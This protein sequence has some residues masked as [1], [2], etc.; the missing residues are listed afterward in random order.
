MTDTSDAT[1]R[2]RHSVLCTN[3][4]HG[5]QL[6][7]D[8]SRTNCTKETKPCHLSIYCEQVSRN[9]MPKLITNISASLALNI[10]PFFS[11]SAVRA[12]FACFGRLAPRQEFRQRETSEHRETSKN[13]LHFKI[14]ARF[15][16]QS[17]YFFFATELQESSKR[18]EKANKD[19]VSRTKTP[20]EGSASLKEGKRFQRNSLLCFASILL[21]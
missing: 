20:K 16:L 1:N 10:F 19:L 6:S 11:F 13:W 8:Q 21:S 3:R 5:D 4:F 9:G 18:K 7:E 17:Y 12:R 15:D 14:P 2:E